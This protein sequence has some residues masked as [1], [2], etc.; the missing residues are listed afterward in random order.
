MDIKTTDYSVAAREI[1][2]EQMTEQA[3][4]AEFSMPEYCPG[5]S[6]IL[7]CRIDAGILSRTVQGTKLQIE[8]MAEVTVF[9]AD[10]ENHICSWQHPVPFVKTVDIP[11]EVE[12]P[13]FQIQTKVG[14]T[15]CKAIGEKKFSVHAVIAFCIKALQ[16][17]KVTALSAVECDTVEQDL[18]ILPGSN[19]VATA[20]KYALLED[21]ID[22]ETEY[23][24]IDKLVY[25]H[26][27]VV[28]QGCKVVGSKLVAKGE[29]YTDVLYSADTG[30][31]HNLQHTLPFS[32]IIDVDEVSELCQCDAAVEICSSEYK[33]RTNLTGEVRSIS[34]QVKIFVTA[35]VFLN[36][37][38]PVLRDAY[39]TKYLYK[40]QQQAV[41]SEEALHTVNEHF[42]CKKTLEFTQNSI[43]KIV[44]M[45]CDTECTGVQIDN[46]ELCIN[47]TV[48]ACILAYDNDGVPSYLE[49]SVDFTY[50]CPL[51]SIPQNFK[52][53]PA[54]MAMATQY[55]LLDQDKL[56]IK[57]DLLIKATV[58]AQHKCNAVTAF[59]ISDTLQAKEDISAVVC[60]AK[61]GDRLW[62]IAKRYSTAKQSIMQYNSVAEV[63]AEDT[64]LVI[65]AI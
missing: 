20:E 29:L 36:E 41:V 3:I 25:T 42:L 45:W 63:L 27:K 14:Y 18:Q 4:D 58:Y 13:M 57:V 33:A 38:M 16:T 7:K 24:T 47:G 22:L 62:D 65:P 12:M 15:N 10:S 8:G 6:R 1:L 61:K 26:S 34:M 54:M 56:E 46:K 60:L 28:M 43:A 64:M 44:Y 21:M 32:Q 37:P 48:L 39:S 2:T 9:Y 40:A 35:N 50:K 59:E 19:L 17:K 23:P 31:V 30:E 11:N 52:C 53:T 55:M 5:I 49:R 51:E